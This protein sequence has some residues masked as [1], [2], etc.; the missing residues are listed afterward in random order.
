[1]P[2]VKMKCRSEGCLYVAHKVFEDEN[3]QEIIASYQQGKR[4]RAK[5]DSISLDEERRLISKSSRIGLSTRLHPLADGEA[6]RLSGGRYRSRQNRSILLYCGDSRSLH[7]RYIFSPSILSTRFRYSLS[8]L[9]STIL[10]VSGPGNESFHMR[11]HFIHHYGIYHY[12]GFP[13]RDIN[14]I[15]SFNIDNFDVGRMFLKLVTNG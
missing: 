10:Q 2:S 5:N 6:G 7:R 11:V 3:G 9:S 15:Q 8:G 13:I 14:L 4:R 12:Y 1:M